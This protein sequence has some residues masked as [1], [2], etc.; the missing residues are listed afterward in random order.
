MTRG[1]TTQTN[2]AENT[3]VCGLDF[4]SGVVWYSLTTPEIHKTKKVGFD[5]QA[6]HHGHRTTAIPWHRKLVEMRGN[7][8]SIK[9]SSTNALS[10]TGMVFI[11]TVVVVVVVFKAPFPPSAGESIATELPRQQTTAEEDPGAGGGGGGG[12]GGGEND[13]ARPTIRPIH[14]PLLS[15]SPAD[16]LARLQRPSR[17]VPPRA[18][19]AAATPSRECSPTVET[20]NVGEVE[21]EESALFGVAVVSSL[22]APWEGGS[23]PTAVPAWPVAPVAPVVPVAPA[24]EVE[25]FPVDFRS[26]SILLLA[27]ASP[28]AVAADTAD[29][30]VAVAAADNRVGAVG[31]SSARPL[32]S[33]SFVR[34]IWPTEPPRS[35]FVLCAAFGTAYVGGESAALSVLAPCE[36]GE[37]LFVLLPLEDWLACSATDG[38]G[39]LPT[40]LANNGVGPRVACRRSQALAQPS[41]ARKI[42][43]VV[44]MQ[45]CRGEK[46]GC[47][48]DKIN[49]E[50]RPSWIT[51]REDA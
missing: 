2:Q 49:N 39:D 47:R 12:E 26:S 37:G 27:A 29:V 8:I 45:P 31:S 28:A 41:T 21:R 11:V 34:P 6:P 15:F 43:L 3:R 42:W 36:L 48:G 19:A 40:K 25:G 4:S 51:V 24:A 38:G 30:A 32:E 46:E 13:A 18:T 1:E 50:A 17:P 5:F 16:T 10:S 9:S 7:L 35:C 20:G 33:V 44:N 23:G 22:R 14:P